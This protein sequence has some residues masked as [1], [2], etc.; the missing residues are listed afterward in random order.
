[1]LEGTSSFLFL[2]LKQENASTLALLPILFQ[3]DFSRF[4]FSLLK[5][6]LC[7]LLCPTKP[8]CTPLWLCYMLS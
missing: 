5:R 1:M 3:S 4:K 7:S 2:A 8:V 6:S